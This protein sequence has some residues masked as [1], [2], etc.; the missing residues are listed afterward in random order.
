MRLLVYGLFPIIFPLRVVKDLVI[1]PSRFMDW[2][3]VGR[4]NRKW[5]KDKLLHLLSQG[6]EGA[7]FGCTLYFKRTKS[8]S[9]GRCEKNNISKKL[10]EYIVT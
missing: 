9:D 10:V 8:G 7:E 4:D 1:Y 2:V 5:D 6:D 3:D